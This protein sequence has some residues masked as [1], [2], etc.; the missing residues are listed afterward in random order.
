MDKPILFSGPM[1]RAI[2]EGRKT[3]TRRALNLPTKNIYEHPKMG[4]WA[5]STIGGND[6]S[7]HI[8][9]GGKVPT[10]ET[11]C[12][13]H[14]TTGDCIATPLQVG[15]RLWVREACWICPPG[16]TD[17][18]VNP[19][20]P[21]RQEVAYKADDRKGGTAEAARDYNL[22][23]TPS[24]HMPRWASRITLEVTGVKV[25]RLQD[26]S[27]ADC[28]AEGCEQDDAD[29]TPV[30][31]VRGTNLLPHPATGQKCYRLLWQS[32]NGPGSW[33][34][35]PWVAAYSFRVVHQSHREGK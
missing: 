35:N 26:I 25:E 21:R 10:K 2:L 14:Q 33:D 30:W 28:Y 1:V 29:G 19:M 27:E 3:M 16:W 34:A 17:T 20:G 5:A 15:D 23:L 31:Y 24:I 4:G 13:W 8:I 12:I 11:V 6:G 9:K 22:K 7:F 18:P 32:I